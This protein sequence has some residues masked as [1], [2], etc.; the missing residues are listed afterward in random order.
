M[1]TISKPYVLNKVDEANGELLIYD[2]VGES[3]W[4]EGVTAKSFATDLKALG[5]KIKN[6]TVRINSPGG[7]V[8]DGLAIYNSLKQH[9]ANVTVYIDGLAASIASVIAMAGDEVRMADTALMMIHNPQGSAVGDSRVMR[10]VADMMDKAKSQ[11]IKAYAAKTGRG[12]SE[13]S[14]MLDDSTWMTSEEAYE[15]GFIDGI[16]EQD[17]ALAACHTQSVPSAYRVPATLQAQ[18]SNL[19][20]GHSEQE[21]QMANKEPQSPANAEPQAATIQELKALAGADSDFVVEQL[22]SGATIA[23]AQ[24]V[25]LQRLSARIEALTK[26]NETLKNAKQETPDAPLVQEPCASVAAEPVHAP[27]NPVNV[28]V[29]PVA[30]TAAP[31]GGESDPSGK[32]FGGNPLAFYNTEFR[33]LVNQGFTTIEASRK[34]YADNPGIEQALLSA[35]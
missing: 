15:K 28:G 24:A 19:L 1:A 20:H 2:Q 13:L 34:V 27:V 16:V 14:D 7:S 5:K 3:L 32:P 33:K 30:S 23:S 17:V 12:E 11:L 21:K 18:V 22:E 26:E 35:S 25:L 9:H 31:A 10:E 4:E 8:W 29:Q 6:L